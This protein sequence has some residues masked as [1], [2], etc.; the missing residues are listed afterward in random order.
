LQPLA[1]RC[2][3][4]R[5]PED[6]FRRSE[7][8]TQWNLERWCAAARSCERPV[9]VEPI[10]SSHPRARPNGVIVA[11]GQWPASAVEP[12]CGL[13]GHLIA[14]GSGGAAA[15][16]VDARDRLEKRLRRPIIG[17]AASG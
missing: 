13:L 16:V 6:E 7:P 3:R 4:L 1:S 11:A 17:C 12:R 5:D 14:H 8:V 2:A 9:I 15:E 10:A